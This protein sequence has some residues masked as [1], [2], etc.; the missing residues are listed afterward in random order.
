MKPTL[1]Y[2]T[3]NPGNLMEVSRHLEPYGVTLVSPAQ[4]GIAIEVEETGQTLEANAI[5]K[6]RAYLERVPDRVVMADD[7]G[8]E[9]DALD[10]E[11]GIH[12]RR[13]KD[14]TTAL[15]DQEVIDYCIERLHGIPRAQ[16]GAQFRTV[17]ALGIPGGGIELFDGILRGTIVETPAPLR[18]AGF[19]FEAL[20]YIPEWGNLLGDIHALSTDEKRQKRYLTHRERAV[21]K[22]IPRL[23]SLLAAARAG[24]S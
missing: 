7:T 2:A 24:N 18:F 21:Q 11:P 17:I 14:K 6:A 9:I 19:P 16:R 10:G 13:W 12:V 20:F 1:L 22:A 4:V 3:T 5:L 15:R 23:Q 8:V